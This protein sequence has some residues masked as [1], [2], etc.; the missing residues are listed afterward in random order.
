MHDTE[1]SFFR[2]GDKPKDEWK[3]FNNTILNN[4]DYRLEINQNGTELM[5]YCDN[6]TVQFSIIPNNGDNIHYNMV[7]IILPLSEYKQEILNMIQHL[8]DVI[9]EF[10]EREIYKK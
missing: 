5:I 7:D 8:L 3:N 4:E 6:K 10:P 1:Y 2:Y 9:D